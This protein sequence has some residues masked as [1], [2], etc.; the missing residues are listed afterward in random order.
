MRRSGS[1][2]ILPFFSRPPT[3]RSR[4]SWK[5]AMVICARPRREATMAASLQRLAMSAPTKPGVSPARRARSTS[6][7]ER[8]LACVHL[9]DRQPSLAGG[10]VDQDLTIETTG[11]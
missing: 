5:S 1:L 4:A 9:E 6:A 7:V 8:Q 3:M 11:P 2:T 10:S